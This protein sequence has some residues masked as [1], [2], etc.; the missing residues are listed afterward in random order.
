MKAVMFKMVIWLHVFF[1][2]AMFHKRKLTDYSD[3][4]PEHRMQATIADMFLNN[5]ISAKQC[6]GLMNDG[7]AAKMAP[8]K[9]HTGIVGR[10]SKRNLIR[11]LTKGK[12]WPPLYHANITCWDR[13]TMKPKKKQVAFLLPHEIVASLANASD[14]ASLCDCSNM[15]GEDKDHLLKW[16][17]KLN[18]ESVVPLGLWIDGTPCNFDRSESLESVCL[19]FPGSA[20]N[21]TMRIPV[22]AIT[23][24]HLLKQQSFD[25]ILEVVAWSFRCLS[26]GKYPTCRHDGSDF[27]KWDAK[28][29]RL[30]SNPLGACGLLVQARGDWKMYKDT[31]R[32]PGWQDK[33]N[34]CYRCKVDKEGIKNASSTAPW[35][36]QRL[37]HA[38]L[39]AR[40]LASGKTISPIFDC[41]GFTLERIKIDWL[42]VADLGVA[43]ELLGN[44][45]WHLVQHKKVPGHSQADRLKWIFADMQAFYK[46]NNVESQLPQLTKD[47]VWKSKGSGPK[48]RAKAAEA[49]ALVPWAAKIAQERLDLTLPTDMAICNAAAELLGCYQCLEGSSFAQPKLANAS[50]R[51]ALLLLSLNQSTREQLWRFKPK[52]HLFQELAEYATSCPTM[53]WT[54]R[55]EDFGGTLAN[56]ARSRGGANTPNG[57]SN[58]VLNFFKAKH[59]LPSF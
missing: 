18:T 17:A 58:T 12:G 2:V 16:K 24:R 20:A 46:T 11:K 44:T 9:P 25:E 59:R 38:D 54:Y 5:Q 21:R 45:I 49:R 57:V 22:T 1:T 8:F 52:H 14:M 26:E 40:L 6:Q 36:K 42:H 19:N 47:M 29:K 56:L 50:R 10:N 28:R 41:P 13:K 43:P 23:K 7:S 48:L 33:G 31:F 35:R 53:N 3:M 15:D 34:C 4:P 27:N 30:A 32:L 51:F 55:D 39:M 37:T